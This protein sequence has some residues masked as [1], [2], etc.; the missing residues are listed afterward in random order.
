[1]FLTLW[2]EKT[3]K[4]LRV[5]QY[6]KQW[7]YYFCAVPTLPLWLGHLSIFFWTKQFQSG[8]KRTYYRT[9]PR[10]Q[11]FWNQNKYMAL[12]ILSQSR[13]N[14]VLIYF[15]IKKYVYCLHNMP[16]KR[17]LLTSKVCFGSEKAGLLEN[18]YNKCAW[19]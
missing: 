8:L 16:D 14:F 10:V 3:S 4:F 17:R 18:S 9:D 19:V 6:I 5:L 13:H 11:L 15:S 7:M 2:Q 12:R 1:M